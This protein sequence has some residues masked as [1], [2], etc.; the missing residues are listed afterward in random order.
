M[1]GVWGLMNWM[2]HKRIDETMRYV[3]VAGANSVVAKTAASEK[4]PADLAG[5]VVEIRGVATEG[6]RLP[7]RASEART[8][9]ARL[10]GGPFIG[11]VVE[12]RGV[13]PYWTHD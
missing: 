4:K 12:I 11:T 13:E 8:R 2:G 10:G 7:A 1:F 6:R 3:H 9:K 5:L